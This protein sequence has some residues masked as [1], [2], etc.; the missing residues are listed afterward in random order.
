[1]FKIETERLLLRDIVA[2]DLEKFHAMCTN[3]KITKYL[4]YI[5]TNSLQETKKW[6]IEKMTWNSQKPRQSYNL[7][8]VEK[9]TKNFVGWIGIG[10]TD[11]KDIG[12]LDFGIALAEKLQGK[13]YGTE[14]VKA[15]IDYCFLNLNVLKIVGDCDENN[16]PSKTMMEKVGMNFEKKKNGK[17]YFSISK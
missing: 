11:N 10:E 15:L 14:A 8:V 13:G 2:T 16:I 3:E 7:T 1:M 17:L 9:N 5:K 12:D 6:I 4:D